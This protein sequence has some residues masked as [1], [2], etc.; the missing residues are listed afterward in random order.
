VLLWKLTK[1]SKYADGFG[2]YMSSWQSKQRTP[3]GLAF[4]DQWGPNRYAANTAFLALVAADYGLS[5]ADNRDFA[6][7]QVD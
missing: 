2:S 1:D 6:I 3:K 5:P 7:S 4:F